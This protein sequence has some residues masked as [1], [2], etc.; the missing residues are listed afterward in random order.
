MKHRIGIKKFLS[1]FLYAIHQHFLLLVFFMGGCETF[2]MRENTMQL[3][4]NLENRAE[5]DVKLAN[6]QK[7]IDDAIESMGKVRR[8]LFSQMGELKKELSEIKGE[9]DFLKEKIRNLSNE[10][11]EWEYKKAD[12]LFDVRE[13]ELACG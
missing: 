3:E 1:Y 5:A 7:Q 8:K 4:L 9:N 10:K 13:P 11:I 6:M 2:S 12:C